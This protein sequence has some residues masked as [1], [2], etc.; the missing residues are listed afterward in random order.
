MDP[1]PAAANTP[2]LASAKKPKT[3]RSQKYCTFF[4]KVPTCTP[5][6]CNHIFQVLP[7]SKRSP[8]RRS[9]WKWV[10]QAMNSLK[11]RI[12]LV[13]LKLFTSPCKQYYNC[14]GFALH[15]I[16]RG[17]R[18]QILITHFLSQMNRTCIL[19]STA[20]RILQRTH[21]LYYFAL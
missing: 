17:K 6:L 10:N 14:S 1:S 18:S 4:P 2:T 16:N 19:L 20:K 11:S 8:T 15:K 9:R 12:S 21:V 3:H 13:H 5:K 7:W